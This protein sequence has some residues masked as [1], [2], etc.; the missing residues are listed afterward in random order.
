MRF[1][2]QFGA[3]MIQDLTMILF[4]A[5]KPLCNET[6]MVCLE[7]SMRNTRVSRTKRCHCVCMV[8]LIRMGCIISLIPHETDAFLNPVRIQRR[9]LLLSSPRTRYVR[10]GCAPLQAIFRNKQKQ[11]RERKTIHRPPYRLGG[12]PYLEHQHRGNATTTT[13]H[14]VVSDTNVTLLNPL[15]TANTTNY[16]TTW[17]D[18]L[19]SNS[20]ISSVNASST[21]TNASSSKPTR[22]P[23]S[24]YDPFFSAWNYSTWN[25]DFNKK[26]QASGSTK[27]A[28]TKKDL[29]D[30]D[31]KTPFAAPLVSNKKPDDVLTVAD[32]E[33]I[34][35]DSGYIRESDLLQMP[36]KQSK[37][38]NVTL[39]S[40]K[41]AFPQGSVLSYR[42]LTIG[43]TVSSGFMGMILSMTVLPNL[44]LVGII[45]GS[46]Y[47]YEV[48][49]DYKDKQPTNI[50][51]R[52]VTA[53]GR[54][55]AKMYLTAYDFFHGIWF[56]Y[57]TGQLSYEYYKQYSKLDDR[58]GIGEKIDA[59][60][61]RF[62]EGKR[63]F[64]QWEQQNEIGRRTLATLRT[65]WLVE[66]QR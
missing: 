33:A 20:S 7:L 38:K 22:P 58:F 39:K 14:H 17:P 23:T 52:V 5:A 59:W 10:R 61:A 28:K 15:E 2:H 66:E 4:L 35:R 29:V 11:T 63:K 36:S 37:D 19:A 24:S 50:L 30:R 1:R 16:S 42:G 60:N 6:D 43:T 21:L 44:W 62:Q 27:E 51:A 48:S 53:F 31:T 65:A 13:M 32:L 47:G 26:S 64:D 55:L 12:Q 46:L 56:M 45:F 3:K 9:R 34:L 57:K 41:V 49:K 8:F 18:I 40:G 25:Y 54:K